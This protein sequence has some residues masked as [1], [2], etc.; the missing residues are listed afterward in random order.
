MIH[1]AQER[2]RSFCGAGRHRRRGAMG[3]RRIASAG[4][5]AR[6]ALPPG[7]P[8]AAE[9]TQ[10]AQAAARI[11]TG[12]AQR[13]GGHLRPHLR[14]RRDSQGHGT[15]RP[16][17]VFRALRHSALRS[18]TRRRDP[19]PD[20]AQPARRA[21]AGARLHGG[22]G[23]ERIPS[24]RARRGPDRSRPADCCRPRCRHG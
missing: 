16:R 6:R 11:R 8:P 18:G 7:A 13:H 4:C 20:H 1:I 23:A 3:R 5:A 14:S 24:A 17:A 2:G 15:L 9:G 10:P 22:A 21:T 19:E 12:R